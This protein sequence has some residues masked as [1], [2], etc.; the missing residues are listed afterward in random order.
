MTR[1]S[2]ERKAK[3]E[4]DKRGSGFKFIISLPL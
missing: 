4:E 1:K 2:G 3:M